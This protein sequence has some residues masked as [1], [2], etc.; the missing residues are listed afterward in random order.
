RQSMNSAGAD[1]TGFSAAD[2]RRRMAVGEAAKAAE[3]AKRVEEEQ[4]RQRAIIEEFNKPPTRTPDQIMALVTQIVHKAAERG[5]SEAHVYQFPSA[6]CSD[7]GRAINNYEA[8][9]HTTLS[10]RPQLAYEFWEQHL[11]P[12]GFGLRAQILDY[13]GDVGL[14]LTW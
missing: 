12:L 10:G 8:D 5:E 13:P 4:A 3:G 1:P 6:L 9:W 14:S 2:L 11:K 7:R